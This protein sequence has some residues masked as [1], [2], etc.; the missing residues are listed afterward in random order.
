MT[1]VGRII[2]AESARAHLANANLTSFEHENG[3]IQKHIEVP[4]PTI[5]EKFAIDR[6]L[7][8]DEDLC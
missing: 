1:T 7:P 4:A 5:K 8:R 2:V 3:T 6:M